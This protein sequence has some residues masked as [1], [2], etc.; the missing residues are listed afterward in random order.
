MKEFEQ[1]VRQLP[2]QLPQAGGVRLTHRSDQAVV[3][4]CE[5]GPRIALNH[6]HQTEVVC[7]PA[8]SSSM[9]ANPVVMV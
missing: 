5:P 8:L 7:L 4:D 3:F 2:G 6:S 1:A 9:L